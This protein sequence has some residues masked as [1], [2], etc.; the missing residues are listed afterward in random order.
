[1]KPRIIENDLP[2]L[3]IIKYRSAFG[4]ECYGLAPY[5]GTGCLDNGAKWSF[6]NISPV[7][8]SFLFFSST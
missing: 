3:H 7:H 1:M 6:I 4:V 2:L 5:S 8:N